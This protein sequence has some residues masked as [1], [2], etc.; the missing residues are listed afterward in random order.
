MRAAIAAVILLSASHAAAVPLDERLPACLACHGQKGTSETP[1]IP[2]LGAQMSPFVLIQ[3]FLFREKQRVNEIMNQMAHDLTD[4]DLQTFADAIAK[5]PAPAPASG[6][7]DAGIME[8]GKAL[9]QKYRCN[10]CHAEN[11]EGR[12][13]VPR[14]ASQREDF[15][16]KTM[17]EYKTN[18]R[19]GYDGSM[20]EVLQPISEAEIADL[21]YFIARQP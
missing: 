1:E 20:A 4:A 19:H 16:I 17:K 9:V 5:L 7:S 2:S 3:L 11:L 15:L 18:T 6:P 13:N 14:I 21:A 12:D 8:K 10:F